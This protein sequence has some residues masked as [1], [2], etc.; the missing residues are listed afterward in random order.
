MR[1]MRR[2]LPP[3]PFTKLNKAEGLIQFPRLDTTVEF[4]H[5]KDPE[6]TIEGEGTRGNVLD[7]A[8]K[9]DKQVFESVMT[10]VSQTNGK[11]L[12]I[13]T[14]RGRNWFYKGCMR[15]KAI[16]EAAWA[17]GKVPEELFI[18]APTAA[19]PYVPRKAIMDAKR[20][21]PDR[22]FRQYYLAEFLEDGAVFVGFDRCVIEMEE[23]ERDGPVECWKI[24]D[25]KDT[26][27]C[28]G[29]D[30]AKKADFTVATAWDYSKRPFRM[31]GFLKFNEKPYTEAVTEVIKFFRQF[32]R[33]D[34]MLHDKTGLGEVIDDILA[35][36]PGLSYRGITFTNQTKSIMA[37][38][39]ITGVERRDILVP[40]WPAMKHEFDVFEVQVNELGTMRY[41]HPDGDHDD[42]V[43][44]TALGHVAC[45][46]LGGTNFEVKIMEDYV[47]TID[48][49][50]LEGYIRSQI[51]DLDEDPDEGF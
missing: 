21:M 20:I 51:D 9:L 30:W 39:L 23:Y 42:V 45:E 48:P 36:V 19:N 27:V 34:L 16:Q 46:E 43:W 3:E 12:S 1:Y 15:A 4:L 29:V 6:T 38:R 18:T 37:N 40:N 47:P 13:S 7:E 44:S 49:N 8:S 11:I 32:K 31:V 14:P 10:T 33:C 25:A 26:V 24:D 28:G 17:A 5:G 35:C 50:S 22:L 2:M 41:T